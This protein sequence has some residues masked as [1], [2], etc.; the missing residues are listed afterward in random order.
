MFDSKVNVN[1]NRSPSLI[2]TLQRHFSISLCSYHIRRSE[3][4]KIVYMYDIKVEI[5][6]TTLI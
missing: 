6:N 3:K 2:Y 1:L 4:C 5:M